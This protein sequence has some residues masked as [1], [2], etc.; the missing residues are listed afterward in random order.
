MKAIKQ[1]I[2][3]LLVGCVLALSLITN[4]HA[5]V[6]PFPDPGDTNNYPPPTP[7][8]LAAMYAALVA[9]QQADYTNNYAPWIIPTVVG[10]GG[11]PLTPDALQPQIVSD[12]LTLSTNLAIMQAEQHAAVSN[13]FF[14]STPVPQTWTDTNGN[15]YFFDHIMEGGSAGI[16]VT[17]NFESVQTVGAQQLWPGGSS[18]FNLTGTNV[19]LAQWDG[20]D[21]RTNHQEFT[22]GFRAELLR[23]QTGYG[24]PDHP[25]HVAGTMSAYGVNGAAIGFSHRARLVESPFT[26]DFSEMPQVVATRGV[27]ESNHS[28]GYAAGWSGFVNIGGTVY[29]L[30]VGDPAISSSQSWIFGFYDGTANI[31]DSVIYTA[32]T[33]L[34]VFSAG[35]ANGFLAPPSQP[36]LHCTRNISMEHIIPARVCGNQTTPTVDSTRSHLTPSPRTTLW[37]AR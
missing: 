34:P 23:G 19:L 16:K 21:V 35:N 33:Y 2:G 5:Q 13:L 12:L 25:T 8:E 4:V 14:E 31:N 20:G 11:A 36:F 27:R 17:H 10:E 18:G 30:W 9:A 3:R 37:L 22:N 26:N 7:E 24:S 15:V 28:Y 32:Q 6:P 29:Y 1:I